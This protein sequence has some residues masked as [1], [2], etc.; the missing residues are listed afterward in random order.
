MLDSGILQVDLAVILLCGGIMGKK[1]NKPETINIDDTLVK[2]VRSA[3]R[4][5]LR[6]EM[7]TNGR[8]LG[9]TGEV[10]EI[11]VCYHLRKTLGLKLVSDPLSAGF[12]AIDRNSR[13]V[14]IKTR[15]IKTR[16]S[17]S[18][19]LP[20]DGVSTGIFSEHKFAY[21]L[22]GLLDHNYK[23][24]QVWRS[25]YGKLNPIIKKRERRNPSLKSF[26]DVG[27]LIYSN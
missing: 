25:E 4:V 12:D 3:I 19:E 23:L 15:R 2:L 5:A 17:E 16:R 24:C 18:Q 7:K 9:I 13:H 26:E 8:K 14:Q 1:K 6:Y 21:A 10:G 22:L 20:I 11:L 27:K